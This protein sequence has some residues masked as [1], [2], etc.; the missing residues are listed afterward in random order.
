MSDESTRPPTP[1][2]VEQA[3]GVLRAASNEEVERAA[4][5]LRSRLAEADGS[6]DQGQTRYVTAT[7]IGGAV[8]HASI[9]FS[10]I[11]TGTAVPAVVAEAASRPVM[12]LDTAVAIVVVWLALLQASSALA[13]KSMSDFYGGMLAALG[14]LAYLLKNP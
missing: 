5:A 1:A 9:S 2:Q 8:A 14:G 13:E 3:L 10:A 12:D 4:A 7:V 6:N 11:A